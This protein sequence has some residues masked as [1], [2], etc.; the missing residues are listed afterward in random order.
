[1]TIK[2]R[3]MVNVYCIMLFLILSAYINFFYIFSN[4]FK[5]LGLFEISELDWV[6]ILLLFMLIFFTH[7]N[8]CLKNIPKIF[9]IIEIG[10]FLLMLTS[11]YQSFHLYNQPLLYGVRAQREMIVLPILFL[12]Y[13]YLY[14]LKKISKIQ[15]IKTIY[16]FAI[17]EMI[18]GFWQY[19]L[20]TNDF[21]NVYSDMRLGRYR[22]LFNVDFI[23]LTVIM[24]TFFA[25]KKQNVV[26][27]IV[28]LLLGIMFIVVVVKWR[29]VFIS[30]IFSIVS[31]IFLFSRLSFKTKAYSFIAIF[32]AFTVLSQTPIVK[33]IIDV[34]FNGAINNTSEIRKY[35]VEFYL[36]TLMDHPV[37]G[38]G[39]INILWGPSRERSLYN[40]NVFWVDNGIFGYLFYFGGLGLCFIIILYYLLLK[41]THKVLR[42]KNEPYLFTYFLYTII[43]LYT[44]LGLGMNA[45]TIFP[46]ILLFTEIEHDEL[47]KSKL[48]LNILKGENY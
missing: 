11:S 39:F 7:F 17:I 47:R 33:D 19:F 44:C 3:K 31:S 9:L 32:F 10:L 34:V 5:F 2:K 13:Y 21:L 15:I 24:S 18:F 40:A 29:M 14:K 41:K 43:A 16:A 20:N 6:I 36:G 35:G 26:F 8:F 48:M 1:M 38:G 27:N 25:L 4:S 46:I 28:Y 42:K 23:V 12:A 37:L 45:S 30:L 22:Y